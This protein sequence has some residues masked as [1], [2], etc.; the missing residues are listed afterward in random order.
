[1][2]ITKEKIASAHP[3]H[4]MVWENQ[5][6]ELEAKLDLVEPKVCQITSTHRDYYN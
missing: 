1:M 3:L 5:H 2:G 4:L 6:E